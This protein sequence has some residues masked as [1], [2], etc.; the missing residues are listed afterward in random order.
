MA[1]LINTLAVAQE[2]PAITG[3]M[4]LFDY[5]HYA[6]QITIDSQSQLTWEL[7]KG[8]FEGPKSESDDYVFSWIDEN[9]LLL[10][11]VE[12][13]GFGLSNSLNLNTG[14]LITHGRQGDRVFVNPGK[15]SLLK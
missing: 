5:G 6:Y 9:I 14:E 12:K 2:Q 1:L 4:Y 13:S 7:V 10:S 3:H 8:E 15:V 11:W